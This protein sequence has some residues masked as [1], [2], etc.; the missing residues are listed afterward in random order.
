[1]SAKKISQKNLAGKIDRAKFEKSR[2]KNF[3]AAKNLGSKFEKSRFLELRNRHSARRFFH[4]IPHRV[5]CAVVFFFTQPKLK[6]ISVSPD[7]MPRNLKARARRQSPAD[8]E[9]ARERILRQ[10]EGNPFFAKNRQKHKKPVK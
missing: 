5:P 3:C 4:E 9:N 8:K 7:A 1:M 6:P 10:N 2:R